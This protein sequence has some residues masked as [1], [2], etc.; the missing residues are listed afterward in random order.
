MRTIPLRISILFAYAANHVLEMLRYTLVDVRV[1]H[2]PQQLPDSNLS[3]APQA[4][5]MLVGTLI[6]GIM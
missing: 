5:F 6:R 4:D 1:V 3:L 2:R